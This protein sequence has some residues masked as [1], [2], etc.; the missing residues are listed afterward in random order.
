MFFHRSA[1][2]KEL[3]R[4]VILGAGEVG[5]HLALRLSQAQRQVVV[6]DINPQKLSHVTENMDVQVIQGSGSS[7]TVLKSAGVEEATVF[8]AVTDS[9]EINFMGCLFA[10]ILAPKAI[11]LARIRNPEY[12]EY[13]QVFG[14]SGTGIHMM[15]NP[16]EEVVRTIDRL[17]SLPGALEYAEFAEGRIRMVS[18]KVD[19]AVFAGKA[20]TQFRQLVK[21]EGIMVASILRNNCLLIP[22]GTDILQ[23]TDTVSFVYAA[24]AQRALLRALGRT[25]GFFSTACIIGGGNIGRLLAK[26][27]EDK[28]LDVKLIERDPARCEALAEELESTLVLRGDATDKALLIEENIGRMDVVAAVTGDEETN[29]LSCLLAKSLGVEGTAARVNKS[30]YLPLMELIGID[31]SVSPRLAAVNSFLN[32][33]RQGKVLASASVANDAA[34]VVEAVLPE[35]SPFTNSEVRSLNLPKNTLLLAV[36]RGSDVFIPNGL[37]TLQAQDHIILLATPES[38][39]RLE[40]LLAGSTVPRLA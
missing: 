14:G 15:I 6:I 40:P 9:D 34:E 19:Q 21:H 18:Y 3:G 31:H 35:A 24:D 22:T 29:I 10:N 5:F 27:F 26:R 30:A 25:R 23:S 16:E 1:E 33:I 8:M 11:K 28:G 38:L 12:A 13:P 32:F 37:S 7:P 2:K 36:Q 20:L 39:P 4:V 17:L